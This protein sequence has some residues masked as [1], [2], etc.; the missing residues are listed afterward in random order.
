M[1]PGP[2]G[3][4]PFVNANVRIIVLKPLT[5]PSTGV[6]FQPNTLPG[7]RGVLQFVNAN[8]RIVNSEFA[9]LAGTPYTLVFNSSNVEVVNSTFSGNTGA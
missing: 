2:R 8:V 9:N 3:V 5:S 6:D 7:P 1:L 4:L